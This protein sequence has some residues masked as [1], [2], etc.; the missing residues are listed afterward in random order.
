MGAYVELVVIATE[1]IEEEM[2]VDLAHV[3][4]L[5]LCRF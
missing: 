5:I 3:S 4:V 2:A 1:A